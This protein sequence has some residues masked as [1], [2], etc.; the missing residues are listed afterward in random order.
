MTTRIYPYRQASSGA[1]ALA[2]ALGILVLRR[3][4]SR[5]RPRSGDSIINW[6]AADMPMSLTALRPLNHPGAVA[7]A[8]DKLRTFGLLGAAGVPTVEWTTSPTAAEAWWRAGSSVFVRHSTTGQAG[9]G[10][11]VVTQNDAIGDVEHATLDA[12][13]AAPLYTRHFRAEHEY[14]VHVVGDAT[15]VTKKRR[16]NGAPPALVRNH[17][18]GYVYCTNNVTP[19]QSVLDAGVR[20]IKALGLTF[21]AVDLLCSRAGEAR[22]LEVNTAPGLEG[23]TVEFYASKLGAML[24]RRTDHVL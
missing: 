14:R 6:G 11:Q 23:R 3:E 18:N 8:R 24:G 19:H 9:S 17:A 20:A 7:D 22:V 10:I 12:W 4:G 5:Y 16:R 13:P 2:D 1:R 21:G 15:F